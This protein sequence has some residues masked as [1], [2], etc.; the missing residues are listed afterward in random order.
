[1]EQFHTPGR[2]VSSY[3]LS[4]TFGRPGHDGEAARLAVK[5]ALKNER[6]RLEGLEV[7]STVRHA[8]RRDWELVHELAAAATGDRRARSLACFLASEEGYA[9]AFALPWPVRDRA[10]FEDHF[11]LWPLQLVLDQ[12]DRYAICLT[13]KDE[14]RLFLMSFGQIEEVSTV[15]DEIPGKVR[16]PDPFGE[17]E[18]QRKHVEYYHHHFAHVA[19]TVLRLYRREPFEHLILG[20]LWE[21]LPEFERHL[22]RYLRDRIV[23]RWDIDVHTPLPQILE[24]AVKEEEAVLARQAEE[25]WRA[26][27]ES[28]PQ[29]GA[30]GPEEVLAA[31]W[32]RR[33]QALL[34]EPDLTR[35]GFRCPACGR[36]HVSAGPCAECGG[37]TTAV[38]DVL[39]EAVHEA[40]EQSAQVRFWKAAPL[41]EVGSLVALKRY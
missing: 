38:P 5:D 17:L 20:G 24:R 29:R 2:L 21:K 15:M 11:V 6:E 26:V 39:T 7:P 37:P 8:L 19:A 1:L 23:A 35:P 9:R 41:Q 12:A 14:A 33:V 3:Y 36:L 31:L 25:I 28:R 22:H 34:V 16:F 18:Y 40:V 32:Q 30:V 27:Q 13:D 4:L 10:F